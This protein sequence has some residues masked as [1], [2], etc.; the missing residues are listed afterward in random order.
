MGQKVNPIVFRLGPLYTWKSRWFATG[1][2]YAE[3]VKTD[4]SLRKM[5]ME[6]LAN[7]GITEVEIER[8]LKSI[9]VRLFVSRPGVVIGRGGSGIEEL[10]KFIYKFLKIDPNDPQAIKVDVPV[11]EVKQ[12]D[13]NAYLIAKRVADQL[14]RRI[15]HRRVV[16]KTMDA[17]MRAGAKGVMIILSGRIRGAEIS[18]TEKYSKGSVPQQTI[19]AN[20]DYAQVPALTRSGYVG[21]KVYIYRGEAG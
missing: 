11:E 14:V 7:A 3:F 18:R 15:P 20:I 5:L 13:L 8:S 17:V 1:Q 12:A 16:H 10:T 19:R 21:V 9:T 4:I 2:K 6:R